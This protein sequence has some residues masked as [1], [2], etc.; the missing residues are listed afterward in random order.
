MCA[1]TYP[2][3]SF[4]LAKLFNILDSRAGQTAAVPNL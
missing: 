4:L 3:R 2:V 1:E